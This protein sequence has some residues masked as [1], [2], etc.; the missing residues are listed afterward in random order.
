MCV[1]PYYVAEFIAKISMTGDIYMDM[2]IY[3]LTPQLGEYSIEF[4]FQQ[5]S[6]SCHF[7]LGL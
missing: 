1:V 6:V 3:W 4:I 2:L 7:D 5:V